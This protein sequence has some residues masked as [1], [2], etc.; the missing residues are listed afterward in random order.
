MHFHDLG[1]RENWLVMDFKQK[2]PVRLDFDNGQICDPARPLCLFQLGKRHRRFECMVMPDDTPEEMANPDKA[3]EL[4]SPWISRDDA[5][6]I[7]QAVYTFESKLLDQ[8]RQG[9]VLLIGDAAHLMPPFI[10]QGMCSGIRDAKNLAWKL[11][12]VLRGVA[13]ASLLETYTTERKPHAAAVIDLAVQVG[14]VSCTV[15]PAV[16]SA[17]DEA[18]RTGQAPPPQPFPHLTSGLFQREERQWRVDP[19]GTLAPQGRVRVGTAVGLCDDF[20]GPGWQLISTLDA[21]SRLSPDDA[22]FLESI[23]TKFVCTS[24]T[25]LADEDGTYQRYLASVGCEAILA[26]PDFYIF[27]GAMS[28]AELPPLIDDLRRQLT[29]EWSGTG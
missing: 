7:R 2:R 16:A 18:F 12:L 13:P 24:S 10:G 14:R 17:R 8:W 19:R 15:D 28:I 11:S 26:R 6:L 21:R 1:F 23:G 29:S 5:E 22:A 3:W 20:M 25:D 9:R 4:V 27:G